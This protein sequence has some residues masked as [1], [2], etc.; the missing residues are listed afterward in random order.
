VTAPGDAQSAAALVRAAAAHLRAAGFPPEDADRDAG[1]LARGLLG[2]SLADWLVRR[3]GPIPPDTAS[4]YEALIARRATHVPVAYLLGTREFYGRPFRVEPGVLIP[5]PE[6]EL[7]VEVALEWLDATGTTTVADVGTGSGCV[8]VT[9]ALERPGLQIVATD[10]SPDALRVA[11]R[12][13]DGQAADAIDWRL[14][15]LLD[16]VEGPIDLVVSNPPYVRTGDRAALSPDVRDHEPADALFAGDDGLDVIRRLI[17]AAFAR[18]RPGGALLMEVGA[19][20]WPAVTALLERAGCAAVD[21]HA[22]L[23]SIPRVVAATKQGS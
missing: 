14:T 10:R 7:L 4:A 20:Q 17:P 13:A 22:D 8:A 12:N 19:G 18:L 2:W 16:G 23:Q 21:W 1:V 11:R 3:D 5:R 6:T 15:D 9:L